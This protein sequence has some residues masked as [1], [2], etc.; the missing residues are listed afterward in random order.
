MREEERREKKR[1]EGEQDSWRVGVLALQRTMKGLTLEA[2]LCI[3][4]IEDVN[5]EGDSMN[6]ASFDDQTP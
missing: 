2:L 5:T 4:K 6:W 3:L 1:A